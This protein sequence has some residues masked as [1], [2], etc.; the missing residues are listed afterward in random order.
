MTAICKYVW[1]VWFGPRLNSEMWQNGNRLT[2]HQTCG[3]LVQHPIVLQDV[4]LEIALTN[5]TPN[6]PRQSNATAIYQT[7]H[8]T[9]EK[10]KF[11]L[12][13]ELLHYCNP[14]INSLW[15]NCCLFG[16]CL[17]SC[18]HGHCCQNCHEWNYTIQTIN[19]Q[20]YKGNPLPDHVATHQKTSRPNYL[21]NWKSGK[22]PMQW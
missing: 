22:P 10:I 5:H 21:Y 14:T 1:F 3:K 9:P 2:G 7:K 12:P 4:T 13:L 6:T 16:I 20:L 17:F 18:F 11:H 19:E 8:G 15:S